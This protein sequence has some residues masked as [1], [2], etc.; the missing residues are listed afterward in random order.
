VASHTIKT[1][2]FT[3]KQGRDVFGVVTAKLVSAGGC[4][5]TTILYVASSHDSPRPIWRQ[6]TERL[7]DTSVLDGNGIREIQWSP[8][9][10]R[11]LIVLSQWIWGSDTGLVNKYIV[12]TSTERGAKQISPEHAIWERFK[13]P[14]TTSI[15]TI[16]WID[17]KHIQLLAKPFEDFDEEGGRTSVPSCVITP[18]RLSFDVIT[19]GVIPLPAAAR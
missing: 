11:A 17:D 7:P 12:F 6:A 15:D 9:G 4:R 18:L 2:V 14:C 10:T 16:G 1:P 3:S 8:S 5:N 13:Q 19:G